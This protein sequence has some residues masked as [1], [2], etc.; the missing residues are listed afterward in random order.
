[1][2]TMTSGG[3][4]PDQGDDLSEREDLLDQLAHLDVAMKSVG[5]KIERFRASSK[6]YRQLVSQMHQQGRYL[7]P[8]TVGDDIELCNRLLRQE[9]QVAR[10]QLAEAE[11]DAAALTITARATVPDGASLPD[12]DDTAGNESQTALM[13]GLRALELDVKVALEAR[14]RASSALDSTRS[15]AEE[16]GLRLAHR[17]GRDD[18]AGTAAIYVDQILEESCRLAHLLRMESAQ[19]QD[20]GTAAKVSKARVMK[21]QQVRA[22]PLDKAGLLTLDKV[23]RSLLLITRRRHGALED[24]CCM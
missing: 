17:L 10:D 20:K 11:D 21:Q 18:G 5:A 24:T 15:K 9:V 13:K 3:T 1:M 7:D 2:K 4:P 14:S 23:E 16:M 8:R 6:D 12:K 22:A 19:L